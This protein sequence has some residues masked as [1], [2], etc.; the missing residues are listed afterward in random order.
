MCN[1][2]DTGG[3]KNP[4]LISTVFIA[5][6]L[7]SNFLLPRLLITTTVIDAAAQRSNTTTN[8]TQTI[9][10]QIVKRAQELRFNATVSNLTVVKSDVPLI[11]EGLI[12]KAQELKISNG[13]IANAI[14]SVIPFTFAPEPGKEVSNP[15][16]S[17][18]QPNP[19]HGN[20]HALNIHPFIS[21]GTAKDRG[22]QTGGL[23]GINTAMPEWVTASNV[24]PVTIEGVV[25]DSII[26]FEDWPYTHDS[27]DQNFAVQLDSQYQKY[28]SDSNTQLKAAN[29]QPVRDTNGQP[30]QLMEVEWESKYFPYHFWPVAGDRVWAV[31]KLIFDCGHPDQ[32]GGAQTEIHPPE[33]VAFTRYEPTFSLDLSK[34][35]MAAMTQ[36][37]FNGLG[38]WFNTQVGGQNYDFFVDLPPKPSPSAQLRTNILSTD[39][40]GANPSITPFPDS[41]NPTKIHIVFAPLFLAIPNKYSATIAAGWVDPAYKQSFR[42]LDVT[43]DRIKINNEHNLVGGEA[44][45][46]LWIGANGNWLEVPGLNHVHKGDTITINKA[47][48]LYVA[49]DGHLNITT[50]GWKAGY[51]DNI[52]GINRNWNLLTLLGDIPNFGV[53]TY[54]P[55]ANYPIGEVNKN[56]TLANDFGI[57]TPHD[58][59]DNVV[60][61]LEHNDNSTKYNKDD[62]AGDFTL[63]YHINQYHNYPNREPGSLTVTTHV[64][65][66]NGGNLR[67]SDFMMHVTGTNVSPSSSFNGV[68]LPGASLKLDSGSYSV[69][70]DSVS[71]YTSSSSNDCSG[72]IAAGE[73]KYCTITNIHNPLTQTGTLIVIT[74]VDNT[75]GGGVLQASDFGIA[76]AGTNASPNRFQGSE[77]GTTVTM[78]PGPYN[79]N[80]EYNTY[81]RTDLSPDCKGTLAT[82]Q[83]KTCTVTYVHLIA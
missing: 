15:V 54:R 81:Y 33:A 20:V 1:I 64:D 42:S 51:M 23:F 52:F 69:K 43:F 67:A 31:G 17:H 66:T 29:G 36:I 78:A 22:C 77:S 76:V 44:N 9:T 38:G 53:G 25:H 68:E 70:E 46:H 3:K 57:G 59:R 48:P 19:I 39:F 12:H 80:G 50:T 37:Y 83:V 73:S 41:K 21:S 5:V 8:T 79:V 27:H 24:E 45:W 11:L 34:P 30:V 35:T 75:S 16:L 2:F 55:W 58:P 82:G 56:Y 4:I 18:I 26:S 61:G 13:S 28:N 14:H 47:I 40:G 7:F 60:I 63:S 32:N 49:N 10:D 74:H 62:T 65:N 6:L 71:G 72:T